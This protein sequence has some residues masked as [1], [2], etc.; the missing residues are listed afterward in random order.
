MKMI[1]PEQQARSYYET[2]LGQ[3]EYLPYGGLIYTVP[4]DNIPFYVNRRTW[5]SN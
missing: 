1:W 4:E 5:E 3:P 2:K